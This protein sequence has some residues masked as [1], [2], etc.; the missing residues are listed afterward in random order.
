MDSTRTGKPRLRPAKTAVTLKHLLTHTSGFCYD[1]WDANMFRYTKH[2]GSPPP[3]VP[4]LM[5][6]PGTRWQYGTGVD[7]AGRL[8]EAISGVTSNSIFRPTFAARSKCTTPVTFLP[9]AKFDRL[10]SNYKR[11]PD[12]PL[13][14]SP[15]VA[16]PLPR[17]STAA[18]GCIPPPATTRGSC[19]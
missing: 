5:F 1:T 18:V 15:R 4:P 14:Q 19:R 2:G 10:V 12:G 7:W 8:V 13:K 16:L 9:A 11:Q 3:A 6:E 17:N